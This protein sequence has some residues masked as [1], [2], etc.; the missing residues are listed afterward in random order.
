MNILLN[1]EKLAGIAQEGETLGTVL[2]AVQ[3]Q[4]ISE[5]EVVSTIWVDDEPLTAE[6]LAAWKHRP[7][8][9]F[10]EARIEAPSRNSLAING[11][12]MVAQGLS[13][14]GQQREQI[15]DDICQGRSGDAMTRL[16]HYLHLWD[17]TQK[18]VGSVSRLLN[19]DPTHSQEAQETT[20][21]PRATNT[22]DTTDA[23]NATDAADAVDATD[24][25][26]VSETAYQARVVAEQANQLT[27][28]L[29]ELKS[30]LEAGDMVLVG[31]ILDYEFGDITENWCNMLN[32]L[33]DHLAESE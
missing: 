21:T 9:D 15:V 12:Q 6:R 33:A 14:S 1:G 31:D 11:L 10:C 27:E 24:A 22:M 7:V 16:A 4:H 5:D 13:D 20:D 18:T 32:G 28:Q 26:D 30:A 3:D 25:A 17:T 19:I 23:T 29:Q 8:G 2:L